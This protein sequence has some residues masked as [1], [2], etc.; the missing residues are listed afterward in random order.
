MGTTSRDTLL[1]S[2]PFGDPC[3]THRLPPF[4]VLLF[5]LASRAGKFNI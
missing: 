1:V 4:A 5:L 3:E 2:I